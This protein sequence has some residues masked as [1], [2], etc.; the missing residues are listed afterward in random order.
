MPKVRLILAPLVALLGPVALAGGS[1][2]TWTITVENPQGSRTSELTVA[3]AEGGYSGSLVGQRGTAELQSI[4]V[5]GDSFSFTLTM[6]TRMGEFELTYS[7][8]VSGDTLSGNIETSMGG[9]PFTA[10][11][12]E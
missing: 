5:E 2:G 1:A 6:E 9:R 4:N 8:T 12:K 7:G 3:E 10:V 11:R